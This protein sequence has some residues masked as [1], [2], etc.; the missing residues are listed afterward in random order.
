MKKNIYKS[1]VCSF[2]ALAFSSCVNNWLE[3]EPCDGVDASTAITSSEDLF[4]ARTAM[5]QILKGTSSYPDYYGARMIYYGDV[6]GEDMQNEPSGSR[7]QALYSMSFK[8]A[9]DAPTIW[10]TPYIVIRRA[11]RILEAAAGELGGDP[12]AI[13]QY[14]AEAKV[15]RALAHFD[16]VRVYGKTYTA[17]NGAS[18]GVPVV[19]S[20]L[21]TEAK[22]SRSSVS[23]VYAQVLE[24]LTDAINSNNLPTDFTPGYIN[25]WAAKAILTRVYLTMGDN[26][27]ALSTAEDII[28]NSPYHLWANS[29]Y[30]SAFSKTDPNHQYEILFELAMT[31]T[32]DWVDRE[33]IANIYNEDGYA[34]AIA[35]ESFLNMMKE[36]PDDVRWNILEAPHTEQFKNLYG[37]NHVFVNKYLAMNAVNSIP[38]FRLSEVY[39][40]AAEAAS[41]LNENSKA[42]Q[43]LNAIV[44]R[45]NPNYNN[46]NGI[47]ESDVTLSRI[48]IERRKELIGEGQ[49]FFD[50]MRN[51]ETIVRYTSEADQGWHR[52][53]TKEAQSYNRDYFKSI[54]PI[55]QSELNVNE[56]MVN[57][58]NPGY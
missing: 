16:L 17:D 25:V 54:L 34:D 45:A 49:R 1:I 23:E 6:R 38:L 56:N 14:S 18:L 12:E 24:D 39:L 37:T 15:V 41:K 42:A 8:T 35:T 46:G 5:Y 50:A 48:L 22:P 58:Q 21:D 36:D 51:N 2:A 9:S 32:T 43:Y 57:Q 13:K 47:P 53:L 20:A 27:K 28:Q 52:I 11:N 10:Q 44:L 19:T 31:G 30:A 33:G 29:E 7:T 4:N 40:S 26:S 55:P 3:T